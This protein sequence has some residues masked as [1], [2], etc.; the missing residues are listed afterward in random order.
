MAYKDPIPKDP[1]TSDEP[2]FSPERRQSNLMEEQTELLKK[3]TE[4][5]KDLRDINFL[6]MVSTF[7]LA[8]C[9]FFLTLFTLLNTEKKFIGTL[10]SIALIIF[11]FIIA[12]WIKKYRKIRVK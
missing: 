8:I 3:Q 5:N 10:L 12:M 4:F 2:L 9:S 11:I 7:I 1:L 6:L